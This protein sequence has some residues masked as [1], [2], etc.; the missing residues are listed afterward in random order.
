ML[1]SLTLSAFILT[2]ASSLTACKTEDSPTEQDVSGIA[3]D[4]QTVASDSYLRD[5]ADDN[6]DST[7]I[8]STSSTSSVEDD[9]EPTLLD[10]D[11]LKEANIEDSETVLALTND[12]EN[13][14]MACVLAEKFSSKK[15]TIALVNKSNYRILK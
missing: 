12:D 11:I 9:C 7:Q 2:I 8:A 10:E 5:E 6:D 13:N 4:N 14:V 1:K 15:R 3:S